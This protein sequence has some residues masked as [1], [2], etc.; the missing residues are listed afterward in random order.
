M[1]AQSSLRRDLV[2]VRQWTAQRR[3]ALGR[4]GN[5]NMDLPQFHA[6]NTVH[7]DFLDPMS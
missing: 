1:P 3:Q 4:N 5:R 2:S 6:F 7:G